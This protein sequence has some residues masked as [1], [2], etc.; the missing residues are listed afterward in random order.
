MDLQQQKAETEQ[1]FRDIQKM[2]PLPATACISFQFIADDA[3]A[4]WDSFT[5]AA[6]AAG[7]TVEWYEAE[8]DDDEACMEITSPAVALSVETLWAHEEKL[9]LMG[10]IHG[11]VADG[12][13]FAEAE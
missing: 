11:F 5:D 6:E 9:T 7:Y 12:W 3:S 8:D 2:E 13:G 1:V 4:D 10:A